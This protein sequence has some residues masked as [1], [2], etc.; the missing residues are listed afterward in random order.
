VNDNNGLSG[1]DLNKIYGMENPYK[2]E[3]EVA[4]A[5]NIP[6]NRIVGKY[7]IG[8]NPSTFIANPSYT[9]QLDH[10]FIS[11]WMR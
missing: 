5:G 10:Y 8:A 11:I 9:G 1:L 3:L 4:F 7:P 2:N 6:T